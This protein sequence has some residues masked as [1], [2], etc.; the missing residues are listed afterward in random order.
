MVELGSSSVAYNRK[1]IAKQHMNESSKRHSKK[2]KWQKRG[3]ED[4]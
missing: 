1:G 2:G 3:K 4:V